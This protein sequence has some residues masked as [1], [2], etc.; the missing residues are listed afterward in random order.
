MLCT[1]QVDMAAVANL[2]TSE[3]IVSFL[4]KKV[5]FEK[6]SDMNGDGY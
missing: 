4:M 3:K 6:E 1:I 2:K 5:D